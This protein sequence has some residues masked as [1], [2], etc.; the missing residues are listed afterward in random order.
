MV[1]GGGITELGAYVVGKVKGLHARAVG[2]RKQPP[3]ER[4]HEEEFLHRTCDTE[5]F[6][7]LRAW[8]GIAEAVHHAG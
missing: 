6:G 3:R 7:R 8:K 4:D 1:C 5:S 2:G